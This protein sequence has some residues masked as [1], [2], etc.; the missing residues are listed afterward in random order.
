MSKGFL[1]IECRN[2]S[3]RENPFRTGRIWVI[4]TEAAEALGMD[5]SRGACFL[6]EDAAIKLGLKEPS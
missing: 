5:V 4:K 1:L 6:E 3:D 2:G